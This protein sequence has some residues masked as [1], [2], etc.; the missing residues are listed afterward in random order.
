MN[1][2]LASVLGRVFGS[3]SGRGMRRVGLVILALGVGSAAA[4]AQAS[5]QASAQAPAHPPLHTWANAEVATVPQG[6]SNATFT[7]DLV[8]QLGGQFGDLEVAGNLA[9]VAQGMHI[10]ILDRRDPAGPR[11]LGLSEA[12]HG[13]IHGTAHFGD[14]LYVDATVP[15]PISRSGDGR[16]DRI[17]VL[18]VKDPAA[19]KWEGHFGEWGYFV[20]GG[21]WLGNASECQLV[22]RDGALFQNCSGRLAVF[23]LS[24]PG[25]PRLAGQL[26]I[27]FGHAGLMVQDGLA[28]VSLHGEIWIFDVA[29]P[30]GMHQVS[31]LTLNSYG[32]VKSGK[33]LYVDDG[34]QVLVVFDLADPARPREVARWQSPTPSYLSWIT[35]VR[36]GFVYS[37]CPKGICI[38]DF[39]DLS[40]PKLAYELPATYRGQSSGNV[41]VRAW[42]DHPVLVVRIDQGLKFSDISNPAAPVDLGA[43]MTGSDN[44]NDFLTDGDQVLAV[45]YASLY[46]GHSRSDGNL[47]A[48]ATVHSRPA[49]GVTLK[50]ED[51]VAYV[52]DQTGLVAIDIRDLEHPEVLGTLDG[53]IEDDVFDSSAITL[54]DGKVYMCGDK[55]VMTIIDVQDPRH[56][57]PMGKLAQPVNLSLANCQVALY[58][59]FAMVADGTGGWSVVDIEDPGRP[60]LV[61][62]TLDTLPYV[63]DVEVVGHYAL[64]VGDPVSFRKAN[65]LVA[66]DITDPAAPRTVATLTLPGTTDSSLEVV[67]SYAYVLHNL[68]DKDDPLDF[69]GLATIDIHD[70]ANPTLSQETRISETGMPPGTFGHNGHE[71]LIAY[72]GRGTQ[73]VDVAD[74]LLPRTM[75]WWS[76]PRALYETTGVD[77]VADELVVSSLEAGLVILRR[78]P[79]DRDWSNTLFLPRLDLR[80]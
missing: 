8:A 5:A 70:P 22:V 67:G 63:S 49:S 61:K 21:R 37:V 15:M 27:D 42:H 57:K 2:K 52:L 77:A 47:E 25:A 18:N 30:A 16:V 78:T 56:M 59:L 14:Y 73:I 35:F 6:P 32:A 34:G 39:R 58:G 17:Y 23:D 55:N 66:V 54:R 19:P 50:T 10:L 69:S 65:R 41:W 29:T 12:I 45:G 7:P 48:L 36:D 11:Q 72:Y 38:L 43:L 28:F 60:M 44:V 75:T 53:F 76:P 33:Y 64:L 71:L 74:P 80:R 9:F 68:D 20:P 51:G 3:L 62:Q 40:S 13:T 4:P 79:A 26:A 31:K 1:W 24:A 46:T